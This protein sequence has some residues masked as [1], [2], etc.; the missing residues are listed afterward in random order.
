MKCLIRGNSTVILLNCMSEV[1]VVA[2]INPRGFC[3]ICDEN[4]IFRLRIGSTHS[5]NL[6]T[7]IEF[8]NLFFLRYNAS[9]KTVFQCWKILSRVLT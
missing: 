4:S 5:V 9:V 3:Y 2:A 7:F 1:V 6:N 8:Y